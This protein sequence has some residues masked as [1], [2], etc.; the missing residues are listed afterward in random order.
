MSN[1]ITTKTPAEDI[2]TLLASL[3]MGTIGVDIFVWKEPDDSSK[4]QD[5]II[6]IYD[7]GQFRPSE[8]EYVYEYP[9][10]QLRYRHKGGA[11][12]AGLR[13]VS[14]YMNALHGYVG[15]IGSIKYP[16]V[17]VVNGPLD[18]G[19]DDRGRVRWTFNCEMHRTT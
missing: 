16:V 9:T 19:E 7:T 6:T 13:A 5:N 2:A 11:R 15:Q 8:V 18:L 1:L 12:R 17:R 4:I 3:G 10:I 14:S